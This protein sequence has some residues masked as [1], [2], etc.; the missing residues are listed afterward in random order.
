V[1]AQIRPAE[2]R[3]RDSVFELATAF[4]TKLVPHRPAFDVTFAR[5]LDADGSCLLVAEDVESG[6][7]GYLLGFEHAAFYADGPIGWVEEVM[8]DE[9]FRR[10]G[11]GRVLIAT[12]DDWCRGRGARFISL[13]TSRAPE[14]YEAIGFA[15]TAT[16]FRRF[17]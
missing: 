1:Q 14:F 7:V 10:S 16:Y 8:V 15:P 9:A 11:L 2:K 17:M 12:F 4:A 13:A 6:L 5:V 3:D